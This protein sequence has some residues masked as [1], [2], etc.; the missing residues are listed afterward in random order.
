MSAIQYLTDISPVLNLNDLFGI[1]HNNPLGIHPLSVLISIFIVVMIMQYLNYRIRWK[2][3][4]RHYPWVYGLFAVAS[5][6]IIYYAFMPMDYQI[7]VLGSD[8]CVY[9]K[10]YIGWWCDPHAVGWCWAIVGIIC[11][12][13][14]AY[15]IFS[16]TQQ[17]I[18][19]LSEK[20]NIHTWKEYKNGFYAWLIGLSVYSLLLAISP[21]SKIGAWVLFTLGV[22]IAVFV[23]CKMI[24]DTIRSKSVWSIP[25]AL[26][27]VIGVGLGM[28]VAYE[29]LRGASLFIIIILAIYARIHSV[30]KKT[31]K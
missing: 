16:V 2:D 17:I 29:T 14:V 30:K 24:A 28:V 9:G 26:L 7:K 15:S 11:G 21:N 22:M 25:L 18:A 23:L 20:A 19:H 10:D 31:S 4:E 8:L 5:L 3:E 13:L 12:I 27:F 1:T 6:S